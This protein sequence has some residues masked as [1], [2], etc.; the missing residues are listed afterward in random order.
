V[1]SQASR[2]EPDEL[3]QRCTGAALDPEFL[4]RHLEQRYLGVASSTAPRTVQS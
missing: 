4:R 2:F 1:W 3:L